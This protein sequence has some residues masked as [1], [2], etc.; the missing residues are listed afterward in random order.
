MSL[1]LFRHGDSHPVGEEGIGT[2]EERTLTP[3]GIT[4]TREACEGL[5]RLGVKGDEIWS[6]PLLRARQTADILAQVLGIERIEVRSGLA[7]PEEMGDLFTAL[8]EVPPDRNLFLVGHQ[9][10]LGDWVSLLVSGTSEGEVAIS[11]SGVARIE[12]SAGRKPPRGELR[13]LLTPNLL[14]RHV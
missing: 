9:P 11:K 2:D 14:R 12:L 4:E 5:V 1:Y 6:S 10:Y 7:L 3:R 13:W 8:S